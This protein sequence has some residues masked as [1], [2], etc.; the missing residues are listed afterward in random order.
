MAAQLYAAKNVHSKALLDYGIKKGHKQT[1]IAME[2]TNGEVTEEI[3]RNAQVFIIFLLIFLLIFFLLLFL[4]LL[5][6]LLINEECPGVRQPSTGD[7]ADGGGVQARR[8][9]R[10]RHG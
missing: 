9:G 10:A 4:I 5:V 8:E 1:I 6:F 3:M 7:G 2:E